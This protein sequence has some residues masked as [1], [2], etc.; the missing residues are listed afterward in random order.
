MGKTVQMHCEPSVFYDRG[1]REYDARQVM[2][3]Y[4]VY[5]DTAATVETDE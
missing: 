1:G 4:V 2:M 3:E 5:L